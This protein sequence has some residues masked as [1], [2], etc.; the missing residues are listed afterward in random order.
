M[1]N[2]TDIALAI[3]YIKHNQQQSGGIQH[4]MSRLRTAAEHNRESR[5][6]VE[7]LQSE[8]QAMYERLLRLEPNSNHIYGPCTSQL[9]QQAQKSNSQAFARNGQ[10][11][12][13]S[14]MQ[15]SH[16]AP[17]AAQGPSAMQGVEYGSHRE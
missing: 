9:A 17:N 7:A 11:I 2:F 8:V 12:N 15:A 1:Y 13:T 10:P 5:K 14:P 4:E 16:F 6:E 3:D